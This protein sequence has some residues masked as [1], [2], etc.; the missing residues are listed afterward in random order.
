[1]LA[2]LYIAK[3]RFD[4]SDGEKWQG[5]IAWAK[6][7]SLIEVVSLDSMLCPGLLEEIRDE[8]WE[9]IVNEDFRLDYYIHLNCLL[10]RVQPFKRRNILGLYRNPSAHIDES[11]FA[12]ESKFMGYDLIDEQTQISAL[13]NCGGFPDVFQNNE[14]N[15]YGLLD[16]FQRASEVRSDLSRKHPNEPHA[17][18]EL[19]AIW[20]LNETIPP[21]QH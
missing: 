7:P 1:M 17:Q 11:P 9:H 14:I 13:I 21:S 5:Y 6:L 16:N 18:C 20:R 3:E 10:D 19:Y 4:P 15:C 2:P 12:T 8:D